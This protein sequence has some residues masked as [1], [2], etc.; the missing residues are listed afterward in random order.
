MLSSMDGLIGT[1]SGIGTL[2][3]GLSVP[4]SVDGRPYTGE[5]T[6]VPNFN[7]QTLDTNGKLMMD[8]VSVTAIPVEIT[9]NE[10]GGR[11]VYIGGFEIY[12][13]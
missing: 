9:T 7:E 5:Y 13:E 1:L 8:D 11:T 2:T 6:V 12:G 3:G 4:A 10:Q